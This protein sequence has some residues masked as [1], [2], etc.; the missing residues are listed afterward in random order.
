MATIQEKIIKKVISH[1]QN[2]FQLHFGHIWLKMVPQ[3]ENGNG[4]N[5]PKSKFLDQKGNSDEVTYTF[6]VLQQCVKGG[7]DPLP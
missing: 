7:H 2:L 4:R 6:L 1:F 5:F 3:R